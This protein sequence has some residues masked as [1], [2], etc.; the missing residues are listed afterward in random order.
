MDVGCERALNGRAPARRAAKC[1]PA[2]P[3][4]GCP[5][6][7]LGLG[8]NHVSVTWTVTANVKVTRDWVHSKQA[9]V[10]KD[11]QETPSWQCLGAIDPDANAK[12]GYRVEQRHEKGLAI[13]EHDRE[14][15]E[16]GCH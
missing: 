5:P 10:A 8:P 1:T 14:P 3:S 15:V 16:F 11:A 12:E 13:L 7:R 6:L 9:A 2:C 4:T